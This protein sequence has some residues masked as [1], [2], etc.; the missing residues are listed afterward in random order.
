MGPL[1][2]N[3]YFSTSITAVT[4][5]EE[6]REPCLQWLDKQP[7]ASVVFVSFGSVAVLS[8]PQIHEIALGLEASGQRFLLAL[9]VPPNPDNQPLLP[10]LFEERTQ[11]RGVVLWGW[12]PQLWILSHPSLAGFVSHC[13]WNSSLESICRGV[14]LL[15]WP[16]QAEQAMNARY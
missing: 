14:P 3:A 12:A 2:P 7:D 16:I 4:G 15:T 10:E 11:E 1:L 6:N 8:I 5:T 13:G 9:R